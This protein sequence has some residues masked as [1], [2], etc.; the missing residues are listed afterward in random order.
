[1]CTVFFVQSIHNFY[2]SVKRLQI[3]HPRLEISF[4][5]SKVFLL[6]REEQRQPHA[7]NCP[8]V[9]LCGELSCA[10]TLLYIWHFD[11]VTLCVCHMGQLV[12]Q[13]EGVHVCMHTCEWSVYTGCGFRG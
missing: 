11:S 7:L 6:K 2:N 13:E 8:T 10:H 12:C 9:T 4:G 3:R 1:M 5:C